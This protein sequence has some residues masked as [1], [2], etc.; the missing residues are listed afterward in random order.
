[1]VSTR[2]FTVGTGVACTDGAC[3][4]VVRVVVDPID[5]EVT[6]LVV[7]PEHRQGVG[8]LVP[9]DLVE[10]NGSAGIR[11]RCPLAEFE[12]LDPAEE[13]RFL[14]GSEGHG[15]YTAEQVLLWPYFGGNTTV[16][17][18]AEMLPAGEVTIRRGEEVHAS[19][20]PIGLVEGLVID[21]ATHHV[22]HVL[23]QEGHLWGRKEVAVPIGAVASVSD[24]AVRLSL[25]RRDI[26]RLPPR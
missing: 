17:V 3:G 2:Q 13:T 14:P 20:G 15:P 16:P 9:L 12:R 23:L 10:V 8:R 11:L 21:T 1:M 4:Q 18:T 5:D 25:S 6:H 19:D 22:T 24:G 7:E 26:E